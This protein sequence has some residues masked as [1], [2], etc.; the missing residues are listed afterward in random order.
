MTYD[1]TFGHVFYVT[2]AV[3][4]NLILWPSLI[5]LA[6]IKLRNAFAPRHHRPQLPPQSGVVPYGTSQRRRYPYA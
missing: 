4:F 3:I 1:S 6:V 5:A 2:A